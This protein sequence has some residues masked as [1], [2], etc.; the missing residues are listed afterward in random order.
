[1]IQSFTPILVTHSI[2][3]TLIHP[4]NKKLCIPAMCQKP[5]MAQNVSETESHGV[6]ISGVH[7]QGQII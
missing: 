1:M 7:S 3:Y 4:L 6:Y 2:L 5:H